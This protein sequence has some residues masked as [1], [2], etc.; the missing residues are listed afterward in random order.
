MCFAIRVL[1]GRTIYGDEGLAD[2]RPPGGESAGTLS[3][4]HDHELP[5]TAAATGHRSD[6]RFP[7]ADRRTPLCLIGAIRL[8]RTTDLSCAAGRLRRS[9]R[10]EPMPRFGGHLHQIP[11]FNGKRRRGTGRR[12]AD[13]QSSQRGG[14]FGRRRPAATC[15][16]APDPEAS[17]QPPCDA[18]PA[19]AQLP[20]GQIARKQRRSVSTP[21]RTRT[22][23]LLR[24]RQL[25]RG[26]VCLKVPAQNK[27]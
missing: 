26:S 15:A 4:E 2:R 27:V 13:A 11:N 21:S 18:S 24:E 14:R 5:W 3:R 9:G 17:K 20:T 6:D 8:P 16:A 10:A 12:A 25:R 19:V 7:L 1:S 23:D 22:G